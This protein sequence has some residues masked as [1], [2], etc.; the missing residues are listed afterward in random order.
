M[1]EEGL[2]SIFAID[3]FSNNLAAADWIIPLPGIGNVKGENETATSEPCL[4][5]AGDIVLLFQDYPHVTDESSNSYYTIYSGILLSVL[6]TLTWRSA[7][8]E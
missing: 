5:I 4:V 1:K 7:I 3:D 6:H 2:V 8:L